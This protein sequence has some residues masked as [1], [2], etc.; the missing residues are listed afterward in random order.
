MAEPAGPLPGLPWAGLAD[1]VLALH[2]ALVA[3]VVGGLVLVVAGNL[4]GW[5]QVNAPLF[6][7]AHL[8]AI[9]VVVGEA[10]LGIVCPLTRLERWLRGQAGPATGDG[11][12]IAYWLQRVLYHD[13]PPWVFTLGYTLFGLAVVAAWWRF[14]P[15]AVSRGATSTPPGAPGRTASS[16]DLHD[17][18]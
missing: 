9:A 17:G 13:L 8:A 7:F 18:T 16:P 11:G 4:A 14:P 2:V 10:W 1:A 6:R 12:F 15:R 3:F 5:R